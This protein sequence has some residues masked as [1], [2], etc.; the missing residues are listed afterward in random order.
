LRPSDAAGAGVGASGAGVGSAAPASV[1]STLKGFAVGAA[2]LWVAAPGPL[3]AS[4]KASATKIATTIAADNIA[5]MG[6]WR[7]ASRPFFGRFG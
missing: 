5:G 3:R 1:G 4:T 2:P 6:L 7:G